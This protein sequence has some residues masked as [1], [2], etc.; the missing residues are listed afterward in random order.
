MHVT[1]MVT[2]HVTPIL[3]SGDGESTLNSKSSDDLVETKALLSLKIEYNNNGN[4]LKTN[5][6]MPIAMQY[7]ELAMMFSI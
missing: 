2:G 3:C 4:N 5:I 7:L 6:V 1:K